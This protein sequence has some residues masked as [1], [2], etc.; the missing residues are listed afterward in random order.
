MAQASV[1][2]ISAVGAVLAA[3]ILLGVDGSRFFALELQ[4]NSAI[5]VEPTTSQERNFLIRGP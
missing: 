1:L 4:P 5:T 3:G 2:V